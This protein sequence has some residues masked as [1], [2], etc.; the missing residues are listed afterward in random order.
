[1]WWGGGAEE[2]AT[3]VE[4]LVEAGGEP[5]RLTRVVVTESAPSFPIAMLAASFEPVLA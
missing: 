2:P 1:V 3:R 4:F 5:H